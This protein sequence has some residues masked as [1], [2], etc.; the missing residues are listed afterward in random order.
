MRKVAVVTVVLA[1]VLA[2]FSITLSA[3]GVDYTVK[4]RSPP[5]FTRHVAAPH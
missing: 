4:W 2:A 1:L 5:V 3:A